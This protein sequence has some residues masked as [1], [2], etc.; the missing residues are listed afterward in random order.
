MSFFKKK[1]KESPKPKSL[2]EEYLEKCHN[3]TKNILKAIA[4]KREDLFKEYPMTRAKEKEIDSVLDS[5]ADFLTGIDWEPKIKQ[6]LDNCRMRDID[7]V[8]TNRIDKEAFVCVLN[9]YWQDIKE[10][11][12]SKIMEVIMITEKEKGK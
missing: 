7:D 12:N 3:N 1:K 11:V 9:L 4:K 2:Q 6:A 10:V 5:I 8:P